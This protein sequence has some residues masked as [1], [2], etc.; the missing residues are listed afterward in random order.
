MENNISIE[1]VKKEI[2]K[3]NP[4]AKFMYTGVD[5][6]CYHSSIVLEDGENRYL[7]FEIPLEELKTARFK[8][9]EPAKLLIRWL[10]SYHFNNATFKDND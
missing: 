7:Q 4:V 8:V 1:Y 10:C 6:I 3:Q 9:Q 5:S 2:Y